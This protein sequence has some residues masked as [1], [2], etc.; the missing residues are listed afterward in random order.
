MIGHQ[1]TM[2]DVYLAVYMSQITELAAL[3][4]SPYPNISRFFDN[5][6]N[7]EA[8]KCA[9]LHDF[10]PVGI[11]TDIREQLRKRGTMPEL[12]DFVASPYS[13]IIRYFCAAS[14]IDLKITPVNLFAGEQKSKEFL[15]LNPSGK[16][17][18]L[19]DTDVRLD[20]CVA[21]LKY[22]ANKYERLMAATRMPTLHEQ[23]NEA[24]EWIMSTVLAPC[25]C[26]Q[27]QATHC[28]LVELTPPQQQ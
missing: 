6:T 23:T 3:I 21:I 13:R 20:E 25:M 26:L 10:A 2:A 8:F 11:I 9:A 18:A 7:T 19:H 14:A 15:A 17:P 16:V 1:L 22:L 28:L 12:F 24:I 27:R 4:L 5:I